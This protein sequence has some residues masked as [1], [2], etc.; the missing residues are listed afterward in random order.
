MACSDDFVQMARALQLARR[1]W[2]T[3][4]PN[5]RVGCVLTKSGQVI[6]EGY[7][8]R[9]GAPHAEINALREA[10][11]DAKGATAYVSLEP[12]CHHGR[13]P[14]CT[15]AL[16]AAGVSRV[17]AAM[18][19]PNPSVA[20][21]GFR[22]LEQ[23]G[24][25]VERGIMTAQAEAINL[26]FISRMRRNRPWVRL[27]AAMSLDGRTAMADG[28]SQ[29][30][31]GQHA[32]RDV[33]LLRAGSSAILTSS[34]TVIADDPSLNVR[35]SVSEL[36]I[37]TE[38]VRQPLRVILDTNLSVPVTAKLFNLSGAVLII[39]AIDDVA[40]RRQLESVGAE[41]VCVQRAQSGVNLLEVMRVLVDREIN[42]VQVEAGSVLGGALLE[43]SLVDE[44]IIY[45]APHLMGDEARGL[46]HLPRVQT[47][48]DRFPLKIR[49]VR[50]VGEDLRITVAPAE[51]IR[52]AT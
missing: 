51:S 32:R 25:Q 42:E 23:A 21:Q 16:I 15:E 45:M 52:L 18:E 6:G 22:I 48:A 4:H 35:L 47:M 27:K 7:H 19:D 9:A 14:P 40:K 34:A 1:G 44:M 41:V 36:L 12:C 20:G 11:P 17:V 24:I 29:W 38:N 50:M 8:L 10:G 5:P 43:Q 37:D 2:Y 39:T 3:A 26:G 31:S 28:E 33:Q 30:I 13:T 46:A 49:G